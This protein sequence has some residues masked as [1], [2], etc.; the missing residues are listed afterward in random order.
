M[1]KI[2]STRQTGTTTVSR[3]RQRSEL[4]P[5]HYGH[6]CAA[7]PAFR[8]GCTGRNVVVARTG[9][10]GRLYK[11]DLATDKVIH[12]RKPASVVGEDDASRLI[13]E[14][15]RKDPNGLSRFRDPV[16]CD[17]VTIAP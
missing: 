16:E 6:R 1:R 14:I 15:G 5:L 9:T 7:G 3:V 13:H 10:S 12:G 17:K 8:P 4:H 11:I 2:T